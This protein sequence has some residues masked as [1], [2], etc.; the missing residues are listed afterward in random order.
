[1]KGRA[2]RAVLCCMLAHT[3]LLHG[4]QA[5]HSDCMRYRSLMLMMQNADGEDERL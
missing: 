4:R 1:V 3:G 5:P 2:A